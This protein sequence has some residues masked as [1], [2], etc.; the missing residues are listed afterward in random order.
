MTDLENFYT[1]SCPHCNGVILVQ[2]NELNCKIFRHAVYKHN[3]E[4]INP[5]STKEECENLLGDD[6]IFGCGKPFR[7]ILENGTNNL[8]IEICDYI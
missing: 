8:I 4:Q 6:K 5:H 3:M 1:L 2:K 7:V